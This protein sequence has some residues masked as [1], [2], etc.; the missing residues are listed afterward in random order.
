MLSSSMATTP[1]RM[2]IARVLMLSDEV[3]GVD[4]QAGRLY[5]V[6]ETRKRCNSFLNS[7][8]FQISS[9]DK[10]RRVRKSIYRSPRLR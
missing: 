8:A 1:L 9:V 10:K 7:K 3:R 6:S 5:G 2:D 4:S